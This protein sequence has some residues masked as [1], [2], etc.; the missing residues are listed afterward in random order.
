MKKP[1]TLCGE[2]TSN[3]ISKKL[4]LYENPEHL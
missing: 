2:K 3:Y 1:E 4:K